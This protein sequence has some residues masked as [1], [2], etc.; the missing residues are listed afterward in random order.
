[1][2]N[3]IISSLFVGV[4]PMI[5]VY[6]SPSKHPNHPTS[7]SFM[8]CENPDKLN[9]SPVDA[10]LRLHHKPQPR[11]ALKT[12]ETFQVLGNKDIIDETCRTYL[13]FSRDSNFPSL[14]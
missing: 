3:Y 4:I 14:L 8:E 10:P 2:S 5:L 12:S 1:M 6:I 11:P 9:L 13:I 7:I